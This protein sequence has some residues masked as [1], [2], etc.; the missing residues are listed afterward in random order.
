MTEALARPRF[1]HGSLT[2]DNQQFIRETEQRLRSLVVN[3]ASQAVET[4]IILAQARSRLPHGQFEAWAKSEL[5]WS[6]S[7]TKRLCYVGEAFGGRNVERFQ[8][9]ALYLLAWPGVPPQAREYAFE[10]V[11]DG[12]EISHESAKEILAMYRPAAVPE[13]M[14]NFKPHPRDDPKRE[15]LNAMKRDA[16]SW[17]QFTRAMERYG[18]LH[19]LSVEDAEFG[20]VTYQATGYPLDMKEAMSSHVRR[21]LSELVAAMAGEEI[22][23]FCKRCQLDLP[24]DRFSSNVT[25]GDGKN[26]YCKACESLRAQGRVRKERQ[27][28]PA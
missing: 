14:P 17:R 19:I 15:D 13:G 22:K 10:L 24:R 21:G 28:Q 11:Q 23:K 8:P 3:I 1:D 26:I 16:D 27:K 12:A 4:G 6:L 9:S 5:P 20:D 2:G 18:T 7:Q 25:S